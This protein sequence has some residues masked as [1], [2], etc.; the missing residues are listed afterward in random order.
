[1]GDSA[2]VFT[3]TGLE[4]HFKPKLF[5]LRKEEKIVDD[6]AIMGMLWGF[7][8]SDIFEKNKE[9]KIIKILL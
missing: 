2:T 3:L 6:E 1:M 4:F 8:F 5:R 9:T 7:K